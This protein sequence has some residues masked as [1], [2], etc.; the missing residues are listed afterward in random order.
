MPAKKVVKKAVKKSKP[1]KKAVAKKAAAKPAPAAKKA[2]PAKKPAL[3]AC[4]NVK[5]FILEQWQMLKI[6]P[7]EILLEQRYLKFRRMG[8]FL[9]DQTTDT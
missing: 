4:A 2:A 9:S 8:Q 7:M 6:I 3:V 1:V 5:H